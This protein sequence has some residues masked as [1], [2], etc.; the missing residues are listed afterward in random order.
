MADLRVALSHYFSSFDQ[1]RA[2]LNSALDGWDTPTIVVFGPQNAGK[3]TLLERLAMLPIFPKGEGLCTRVPIRIRMRKGEQ[4][5]PKLSVISMAEGHEEILDETSISG[6]V[7]K[8]VHRIMKQLVTAIDQGSRGIRADRLIQVEL[9][10]EDYPNIDML[11]LPGMVVNPGPQDDPDLPQQTYQLVLDTI[12]QLQDRAIFLAVREAGENIHQ[13]LTVKVLRER[14][15]IQDSSLGVLTKCDRY[16]DDLIVEELVATADWSLGYGYIAT[17]NKPVPSG[18]QDLVAQAEAERTWFNKTEERLGILQRKQGGCDQLID[19]LSGVYHRYL[20]DTWVPNTM[21]RLSMSVALKDQAMTQLGQPV[22]TGDISD[23]DFSAIQAGVEHVLDEAYQSS[24]AV[25]A[26]QMSLLWDENQVFDG[27]NDH[28]DQ[29]SFVGV[30]FHPRRGMVAQLVQA[31]A[32]WVGA[33][34]SKVLQCFEEALRH[35]RGHLNPLTPTRIGR[36]NELNERVMSELPPDVIER[37]LL[38]GLKT[39]AR[40]FLVNHVRYSQDGQPNI[41]LKEILKAQL[42]NGMLTRLGDFFPQIQLKQWFNDHPQLFNDDEDLKRG[43]LSDEMALIQHAQ[44]HLSELFG[45]DIPK[46]NDWHSLEFSHVWDQNGLIWHL[47]AQ[48]DQVRISTPLAKQFF[49]IGCSS[50]STGNPYDILVGRRHQNI[51]SS[52]EDAPFFW[53]K[54]KQGML[55]LSGYT[56]RHGYDYDSILRTWQLWGVDVSG[57]EILLDE[58][59]DNTALSGYDSSAHFTLSSPSVPITQIKLIRTGPSSGSKSYHKRLALSGLELY[60][61]YCD[62]SR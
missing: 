62:L 34:T 32:P 5:S 48:T 21:F 52:N 46:P 45:V 17:M 55:Q 40:H 54:L 29:Q 7:G 1:L 13:S 18:G 22:M 56:L 36:F 41:G 53:V 37:C 51:F 25:C 28:K 57:K 3:S 19:K 35:D 50:W 42:L 44:E 2:E 6:H 27:M 9:W 15:I 43:Q 14:P 8:E 24:N 60:G 61:Y 38:D 23:E 33:I 10:A 49:D 11:D 47:A 26:A 16:A 20:K 58:R 4:T 59:Q 31:F 39:D 12:D 30:A